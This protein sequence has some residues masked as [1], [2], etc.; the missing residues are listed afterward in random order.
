MKKKKRKIS[1]EDI[2][3]ALDRFYDKGGQIEV[4]PPQNIE[5][6]LYSEFTNI[7]DAEWIDEVS[8]LPK[9][10]DFSLKNSLYINPVLGSKENF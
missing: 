3:N 5:I 4:L 7:L 10:L 9:D 8:M 2:L 6:S 1:R